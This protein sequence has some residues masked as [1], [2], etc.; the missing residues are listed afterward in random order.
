[1]TS[2]LVLHHCFQFSACP[3]KASY[4]SWTHRGGQNPS[5]RDLPDRTHL[6]N[7][8]GVQTWILEESYASTTP[9]ILSYVATI[10]KVAL[11]AGLP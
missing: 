10:C 5:L 4:P 9:T 8:Y 11:H 6:L 1:M 2:L 3:L 7:R